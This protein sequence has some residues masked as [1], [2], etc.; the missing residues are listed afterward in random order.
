M[1][2][3]IESAVSQAFGDFQN[4]AE[5]MREWADNMEEKFSQTEK[6]SR[7]SEAA[8]ALEALEEP[9]HPEWAQTAE[10][11]L[12]ASRKRKRLPSRSTRCFEACVLLN[13]CLEAIQV[14]LDVLESGSEEQDELQEYYEAIESQKDNAECVEFPGA[15]G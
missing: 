11:D 2:T 5:E 15:Y 9:D 13:H 7:V 12:P 14:K 8:D 1:K 3:T 6:Y 10:V 4:L